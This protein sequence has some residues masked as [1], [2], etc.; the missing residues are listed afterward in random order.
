MNTS[1]LEIEIDNMYGLNNTSKF[2]ILSDVQH[3]YLNKEK[4]LVED[5]KLWL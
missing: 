5:I 4:L 3:N 2:S 1:L